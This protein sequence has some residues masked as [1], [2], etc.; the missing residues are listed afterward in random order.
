MKTSSQ[1][2]NDDGPIDIE[3]D[4]EID[5]DELSVDEDDI[6]EIQLAMVDDLQNMIFECTDD[7]KELMETA[8]QLVEIYNK[9]KSDIADELRIFLNCFRHK[10]AANNQRAKLSVHEFRKTLREVLVL[11]VEVNKRMRK[12]EKLVIKQDAFI[13]R[14]EKNGRELADMRENF[15]KLQTELLDPVPAPSAVPSTTNLSTETANEA[16]HIEKPY[17]P[18]ETEIATHVVCVNKAMDD[19]KRELQMCQHFPKLMDRIKEQGMKVADILLTENPPKAI[20]DF[21]NTLPAQQQD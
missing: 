13:Y 3:F 17:K 19:L 11:Y 12:E 15:K 7:H 2:E 16:N 8:E 14:V 1:E 21:I 10:L 9:K 20:E 6:L 4:E 18:F 5:L